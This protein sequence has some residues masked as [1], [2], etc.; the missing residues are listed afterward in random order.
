MNF[1]DLEFDFSFSRKKFPGIKQ[2]ICEVI[3]SVLQ[4]FEMPEPNNEI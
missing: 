4:P 2:E 3:C 1:E